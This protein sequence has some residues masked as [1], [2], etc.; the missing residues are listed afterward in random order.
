M[1]GR[2]P[3]RLLGMTLA[4][5]A[6]AALVAGLVPGSGDALGDYEWAAPVDY[7]WAAPISQ[8]VLR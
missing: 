2:R 6:L 8:V 3:G 5:L 1:S 4:S 7:E